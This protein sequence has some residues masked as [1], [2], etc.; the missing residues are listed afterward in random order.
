[1]RGDLDD[2]AGALADGDDIDWRAAHARLTSPD[3][4]SVVEGLES[5]SHFS[6]LSPAQARPSR[7]LPLL[8]EA[9]RVLSI[10]VLPRRPRR[11]RHRLRDAR[12]R[13][14]RHPLHLRRHRGLSRRRRP[15]SPRA[16]T[17]GVLL[18]HGGRLC[19]AGRRQAGRRLARRDGAADA[20]GA[21]PRR[22]LRA[23]RVAVRAG[24]PQRHPVRRSGCRVRLGRARRRPSSACVLFA[25]GV[26][27]LLL[28]PGSAAAALAPR[29]DSERRP[30]RVR[31]PRLWRGA[32]RACGD[33]LAQ[34]PRRGQ[35]ARPRPA[36]PHRRR[37]VV[38]PD[39]HHRS[40]ATLAG[41][42]APAARRR[43]RGVSSGRRW[44]STRQC[45]SCRSR[46]RTP[47]PR[48]TF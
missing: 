45:S 5:L 33:R 17:G 4:R 2:L 12:H 42:A 40:S 44:S 37:R 29:R 48:A 47:S 21:A 38:R 34:P 11:L 39:R 1:M 10:A 30:S 20:D 27:P 24:L 19:R 15:R 7:R 6:A 46:P 32:R 14:A 23:G 22:V 26:L 8:L 16:G 13:A 25:A 43:R 3:S 35:R 31:R 9:A 18:D 28:P 36:L 41:A